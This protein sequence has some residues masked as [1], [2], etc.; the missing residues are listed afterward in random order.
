MSSDAARAPVDENPCER[1]ASAYAL[2][3]NRPPRGDES[4]RNFSL[5]LSFGDTL[6]AE[7]SRSTGAG[8]REGEW[9]WGG[10]SK[11]EQHE[12]AL[13]ERSN[14]GCVIGEWEQLQ[15]KWFPSPSN[16][17]RR[18]PPFPLATD[19]RILLCSGLFSGIVRLRA[20]YRLF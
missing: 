16:S 19:C 4:K 17:I 6:M 20:N 13:S 5:S 2:R 3:S 9:V 10:E 11:R 1:I 12:C 7:K 8:N 18:P 14:G 15:L